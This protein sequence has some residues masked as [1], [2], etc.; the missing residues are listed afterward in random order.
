MA[1]PPQRKVYSIF[2]PRPKPPPLAAPPPTTLT[3]DDPVPPPAAPAAARTPAELDVA[4]PISDASPAKPMKPLERTA[5]ASSRATTPTVVLSDDEDDDQAGTDGSAA[6]T[7][8]GSSKRG[9]KAGP[10][11]PKAKKKKR[12]MKDSDDELEIVE[13]AGK[14]G[15]RK[16][17]EGQ[18][19][20]NK[21]ATPKK[22]KGKV[23]DHNGDGSS[24]IDLTLSPSRPSGSFPA[25]TSSGFAS[26]SETY[27]KERERRKANEGV[28]ARWPTAE[29]HGDSAEVE[30]SKR[31]RAQLWGEELRRNL[32]AWRAMDKKGKGKAREDED[33]GE[34]FLASYAGH[35][36]SPSCAS[37]ASSSKPIFQCLPLS[38]VPSLVPPFPSHPLLNRL[39]AP[40]LSASTSASA[41]FLRPGDRGRPAEDRL[42]TV[43]Y[44]PQKAEE[45]LGT[46]SGSSALHLR[47]WLEELKVLSAHQDAQAKKRRPI[48]RGVTKP[49]KK[50]KKK[51]HAAG[52]DGFFADDSTDEDAGAEADLFGY[53][54]F[55][56]I[57]PPSFS[58]G[59]GNHDLHP[60]S[61]SSTVF[62]TL[63][64]LLLIT[65]PHGSGKTSTVHA[66][67]SE[68]GY[69]VFEVFPGMGKRR[70]VDLERYVGDV[71]RNHLVTGSP[72]KAVGGMGNLFSMF[73]NQAGKGKGKEEDGEPETKDTKGNGKEK[74]NEAKPP[75]QSLILFDEVDVLYAQEHDFWQGVVSLAKES[76]RPIIMTCSDISLV[77]FSDLALQTI[78]YPSLSHLPPQPYLDF[79]PPEPALAVPYLQ[80]VAL[81]EGH[82]LPPLALTKVYEKYSPPR[83][84]PPYLMQTQP[85]ER[86]LPHPSA[87]VVASADLRKALMRLEGE[88]V[89]RGGGDDQKMKEDGTRW[90]LGG[91]RSFERYNNREGEEEENGTSAAQAIMTNGSNSLQAL[92]GASTAAEALS[93]ADALIDRRIRVILEDDDTGRFTTSADAEL[94]HPS[95]DP[96]TP[97]SAVDNKRGMLPF[98]G[99]EPVI[100]NEVGKLAK[101]AWKDG[102]RFGEMEDEE[103]EEK[104]AAFCFALA[105]LTQLQ[106]E[107]S[108]IYPDWAPLLPNPVSS[109]LYRPFLRMMT[110][111]DDAHEAASGLAS[112]ISTGEGGGGSGTSGIAARVRRS[113]RRGKGEVHNYRRK[114]PWQSKVEA[115]WLRNSGFLGMEEEDKV[116]LP[117]STSGEGGHDMVLPASSSQDEPISRK[118]RAVAD[119]E[120]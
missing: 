99:D 39:A 66:V 109:I 101:K 36:A 83:P 42:W 27:K 50:K 107:N 10:E 100:A 89:W 21:V 3:N 86:P 90:Q 103:M 1:D 62:P 108:L 76:R 49:K 119:D 84:Y 9:K 82:I 47:D 4:D 30:R 52:L 80:L 74:K 5:S 60:H 31:S 53:Y 11:K 38:G 16:A 40:L 48:N 54:D 72:R 87:Q 71:G 59:S 79:S 22:K 25:S 7:G 105:Q 15:K 112:A 8:S 37:S 75:T 35:F 17:A 96:F 95:L 12:V 113:T 64:N 29:E 70:M 67:A 28:E 26:L 45:V 32:K 44:A 110:L 97:R 111:A 23:Q 63:T 41:V 51:K 43:K 81:L 114:L 102:L 98:L 120:E 115:D 33:D 92:K 106:G 65:G 104:R 6:A 34:D 13:L 61:A 116:V 91:L 85:G 77:P 46:I 55:D 117:A 2:Q 78:A 24:T 58:P 14:K 73:R 18:K 56:D 93:S 57:D 94:S 19:G 69:E 20:K 118:P 88:L 68:L